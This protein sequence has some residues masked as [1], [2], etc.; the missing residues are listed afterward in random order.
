MKVTVIE[1]LNV[2]MTEV[3]KM[4]KEKGIDF[5]VYETKA[6]DA[7][8]LYER[9]KESDVLVIANTKFP[10]EVLE[11]LEKTKYISIAFTGFDHIDVEKAKSMGIVVSNSRGYSDICVAEL[12]IGQVLNIYRELNKRG[13]HSGYEI[14]GKTVGIIGYGNIGQRVSKLF[15]S[16]G[17][18][19]IYYDPHQVGTSTLEEVLRRSD[20]LTLHMPL[21]KETENFMNYD[22]LRLLKPTAILINTARPSVLNT[23]D[24]ARILKEKR[25]YAVALDVFNNYD[26]LK[27]YDNVFVT[28]HIAYLTHESMVRRLKICIDNVIQYIDGNIQNRVN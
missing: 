16:F 28:D 14:H 18:S 6:K 2:D 7:N 21:N 5:V 23:N 22:K 20:I 12:V 8:E 27:E 19:T 26:L 15:S 13:V 4:F 10:N 3:K 24:I 11:K 1:P 25:I 17:A 9:A